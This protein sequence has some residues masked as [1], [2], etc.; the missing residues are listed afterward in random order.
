MVDPEPVSDA[1]P[2]A[3][4]ALA[5]GLWRC[6]G[7]NAVCMP[8][9]QAIEQRRARCPRCDA[10]VHPRLPDSI[11]RSWAFLLAGTA[12]Y[13]PANLLPVTSTAS[14]G[15]RQNDTIFSGIVYFWKD[16]SYGLAVLVFVA[17]ILVPMTK[18][19]LLSLLLISL[20]RH[21]RRWAVRRLKAWRAL[22]LIGRWSMLDIFAITILAA[23]VQVESL[24]ELTP[25]PG[26]MAFG[27]VVVLT[28][29]ST[30]CFDPRL[31]FDKPEGEVAP[32]PQQLTDPAGD[33][34]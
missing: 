18:L 23:L 22:E 28:M 2:P 26:A 34:P 8:P 12:L 11:A 29:L 5:A 32:M 31:L 20:Q 24:A 25:G 9:P 21:D 7:C 4:S 10:I 16:G 30:H 1:A 33:A 17:S 14:I 13:L 3:C 15:G 27:A 6:R 19:L